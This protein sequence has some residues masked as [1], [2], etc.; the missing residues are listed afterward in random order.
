MLDMVQLKESKDFLQTVI[1]NI[2]SA[3]FIVDKEIRVRSFNDSFKAL[4]HRQEDQVIGE[5]CGNAIGCVYMVTEHKDCGTTSHCSE[6]L[7]RSSLLRALTEKIPTYREKLVRDFDINGELIRKYFLYSTKYVDYENQ[8]MILIVIDDMTQLEEQKIRLEEL[9]QLKNKFLGMAAHDLRS[10]LTAIR[11]FSEILLDKE[12]GPLNEWQ[13]EGLQ[14]I[15]D[16]GEHMLTLIN[17]LLDVSVIESGKL[18][19]LL[20]PASLDKLVADRVHLNAIAAH[21]KNTR[22]HLDCRWRGKANVDYRKLAQ[23][24]DNLLSNAVKYSPPNS[25]ILIRLEKTNGEARISVKDQGPG[26]APEE[27][28]KLFREFQKLSAQ[29][30]GGETSTGLGLSISKRIIEAHKG[31]IDVESE[32]GAGSTFFFTLPLE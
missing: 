10:P 13:R 20:K 23:V 18:E 15:H 6:C 9:N 11:G 31:A 27:K 3:L 12:S 28:K 30:T 8:Q 1:E 2:T 29:P 25:D 4:F 32:P 17:D 16:A 7:L 24:V 5:F 26:I 19:L 14:M 22:L 21:V